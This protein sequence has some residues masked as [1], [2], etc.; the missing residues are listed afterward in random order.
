M[1]DTENSL[2]EASKKRGTLKEND[3]KMSIELRIKKRQ[4]ELL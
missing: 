1:K 3:N 4:V 2:T